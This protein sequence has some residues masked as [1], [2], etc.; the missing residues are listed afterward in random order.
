[1]QNKKQHS[2]QFKRLYQRHSDKVYRICVGY[3]KDQNEVKDLFQQV[4]LSIWKNLDSF[5]EEARITT[6]IYRIAVNTAITFT[7]SRKRFDQR[8]QL[9]SDFTDMEYEGVDELS[10][11]PLPQLQELQD[12]IHKLKKQ[13]RLI[14]TLYLE[15]L[16]Y[17]EIGEVVGISE[18]YVGVKIS[19]IKKE[20]EER[21][22]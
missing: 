7:K 6:W 22:R 5:R 21:M 2:E 20:L 8:F 4:M 13:N 10:A 15:G 3:L 12:C 16:T 19:R 17:S 1:M 18:N 11:D 9:E 14:I